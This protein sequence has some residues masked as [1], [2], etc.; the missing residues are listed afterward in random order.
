[1]GQGDERDRD[2]PAVAAPERDLA[3]PDAVAEQDP[4]MLLVG[5]VHV[6]GREWQSKMVIPPRIL[7]RSDPQH[8][9]ARAG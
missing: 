4:E 1:M 5:T 6:P 8:G 9:P 7:V 3:T 2:F